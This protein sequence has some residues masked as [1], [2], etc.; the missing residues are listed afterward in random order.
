MSVA[1]ELE[2]DLGRL[3]RIRILILIRRLILG[4]VW[5]D[6]LGG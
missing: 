4:W 3:I 5:V 2:L 6:G 1:Q